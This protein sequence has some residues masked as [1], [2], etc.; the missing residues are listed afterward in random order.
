MKE[1]IEILHDSFKDY[2]GDIHHFTIVA[3]SSVL[4]KFSEISK[5][6]VDYE[7]S[8]FREDYGFEGYYCTVVKELK[9]GIAICNPEDTFN[10]EIGVKK[11]LARARANVPA[12]VSTKLGTINSKMVKALLEQEADY[13]KNNPENFIKGYAESK[14]RYFTNQEMEK[15]GQEFSDFEIKLV[16]KLLHDSKS[17]D[18]VFAYVKWADNYRK[19]AG[20]IV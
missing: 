2:K 14:A 16:D 5:E 19:G 10:K 9:L 20:K 3:L 7:V 8:V 12:L 1:Y 13:L 11:A 17:L 4:P 6:E 15:I 18:K